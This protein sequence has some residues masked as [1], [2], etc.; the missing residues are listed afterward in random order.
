MS[1]PELDDILFGIFPEKVAVEADNAAEIIEEMRA[2]WQFAQ[3]EYGLDNAG[4]CLDILD[5]EAVSD[6]YA[7]MSDPDNYG[8]GKSFAMLGKQ[9][10]FDTTTNEGL[11]TWMAIY[12]AEMAQLARSAV[13][14]LGPF[15]KPQQNVRRIEKR[16]KPKHKMAKA[17]RKRNRRKK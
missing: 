9:R 14:E 12:N 16:L 7:E 1:P 10:G 5:D 17:S 3:R 11:R 6:L 8:M 15:E 4:D 2:F 13:P